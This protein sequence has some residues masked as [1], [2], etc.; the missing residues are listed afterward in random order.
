[1]GYA[2]YVLFTALAYLC[3]FATLLFLVRAILSWVM[4]PDSD[5]KLVNLIYN[6]TE[7]FIAPV[8]AVMD[9]F[10]ATQG[11]LDFSFLI[12]YFLLMICSGTFSA[13]ATLFL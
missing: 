13:L 5:N 3:D 11:P 6:I 10:G 4:P 9:K 2:V 1:M 8:R 7:F 12:A